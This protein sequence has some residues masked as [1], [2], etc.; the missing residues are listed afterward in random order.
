MSLI[1]AGSYYSIIPLKA[2]DFETAGAAAF[3]FKIALIGTVRIQIGNVLTQIGSN[4]TL[5]AQL[6]PAARLAGQLFD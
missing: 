6:A 5:T 4:L 1:D 2:T 3:T